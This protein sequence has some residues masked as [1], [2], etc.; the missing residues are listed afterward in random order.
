MFMSDGIVK[1][2]LESIPPYDGPHAIPGVG[3]VPVRGALGVRSWG[4][5]V[6]ELA[7]HCE[8]HPEHDHTGDGQEEVYFVVRGKVELRSNGASVQLVEGDFVR[9]APEVSRKLVTTDSSA[10]VLA[11]GGT[12]GKAFEP[13]L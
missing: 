13:T 9:I 3:F 2:S 8:G 6:L 1:M 7:A 12:P 10:T 5:N 4:M 11:L